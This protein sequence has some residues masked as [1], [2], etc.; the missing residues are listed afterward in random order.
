MFPFLVQNIE[1][2]L[3]HDVVISHFFFHVPLLSV[4]HTSFPLEKS[5]L[6]QSLCIPLK[7]QHG[8]Q[9]SKTKILCLLSL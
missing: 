8:V 1:K 7:M 6:I 3:A 5:N 9:E 2:P 4:L